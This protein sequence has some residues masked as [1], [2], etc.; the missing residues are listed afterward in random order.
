M[1]EL[2]VFRELLKM[3]KDEF[4]NSLG[5]SL[6]YYEKIENGDRK[7]SG[8]FLKKLKEKYPQ[9]DLNIFFKN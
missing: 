3:T 1:A 8:H 7:M 6:S 4:A 5:F 2:K 9:I